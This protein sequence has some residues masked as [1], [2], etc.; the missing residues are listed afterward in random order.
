MQIVKTLLGIGAQQDAKPEFTRLHK[1][2]R[3][4]PPDGMNGVE[5]VKILIENGVNV[6][7]KDYARLNALHYLFKYFDGGN[8][9]EIAKLL[10]K[11]GIKLNDKDQW[12]KNVLHYL[13]IYYYGIDRAELVRTL[14]ENGIDVNARG[15]ENANALHVLIHFWKDDFHDGIKIAEM[16]I[17]ERIDINAKDKDGMNALHYIL[18][19]HGCYNGS[20]A[21]EMAEMLLGFGISTRQK[22]RSGKNAL[23]YL[24]QYQRYDRIEMEKI[25][26]RS[27]YYS[28]M[29]DNLI[30]INIDKLIV[31]FAVVFVLVITCATYLLYIS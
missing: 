13:L 22:D 11:N 15:M 27:H 10:I 9:V 21:I 31:L 25:I 17:D 3:G 18:K 14:L 29:R 19:R 4:H 20:N 6:N 12:G 16:L 26:L 5:T 24:S 30:E 2:L 1:F 7:A 8:R 23:H 28:G